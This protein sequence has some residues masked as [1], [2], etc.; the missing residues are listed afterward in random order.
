MPGA[1]P[2][3]GAHPFHFFDDFGVGLMDDVADFGE[4][5]AAPVGEVFD[6]LVDGGGGRGH[7]DRLA[8]GEGSAAKHEVTARLRKSTAYKIG[9]MWNFVIGLCALITLCLVSILRSSWTGL[10]AGRVVRAELEAKRQNAPMLEVRSGPELSPGSVK[11]LNILFPKEED[12][13]W[14]RQLLYE[15]CGN[16][17]RW[18]S[19]GTNDAPECADRVRFSALK[20]SRGSR[21]RLE[22]AVELG[23]TDWRDLLASAGFANDPGRHLKWEPKLPGKSGGGYRFWR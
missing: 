16:N 23:Q 14:A 1:G 18:P 10:K 17:L 15:K 3:G 5:F 20:Y 7:G 13:Q 2:D 19:E 8:E 12:R 6:L 4:G 22:K 9:G 21:A 11:R